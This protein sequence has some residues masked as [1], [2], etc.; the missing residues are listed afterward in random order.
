MPLFERLDEYKSQISSLKG[1]GKITL[2]P[3]PESNWDNDQGAS[4]NCSLPSGFF[5]IYL[6]V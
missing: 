4:S 1:S 3:G 6:I 5:P 2:E